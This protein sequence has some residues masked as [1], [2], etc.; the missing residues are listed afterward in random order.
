MTLKF[1]YL[2]FQGIEKEKASLLI[3]IIGIIN[4]FCRIILGYIADFPKVD[5]LLLNNICLVIA[6]FSVGLTP[7]CETY[8]GYVA[9]A[10]FFAIAICEFLFYTTAG[11]SKF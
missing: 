5:S 1:R 3:S 9:V 4:T 10:S 2:L 7:L 11:C 6:T 8:A